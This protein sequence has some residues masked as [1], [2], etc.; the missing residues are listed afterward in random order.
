MK[1]MI[2]GNMCT[3]AS[4][5]I[6]LFLLSIYDVTLVLLAV[7]AHFRYWKLQKPEAK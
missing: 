7:M 4:K 6:K 2:R 3:G 1:M 5:K